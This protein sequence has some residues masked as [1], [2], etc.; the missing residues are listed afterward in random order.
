MGTDSAMRSQLTDLFGRVSIFALALGL[1][2]SATPAMAQNAEPEASDAA[3]SPDIIVTGS[4]IARSGKDAPTPVT[5]VGEADIARLALNTTSDI[6]GQIPQNSQFTSEANVGSGNFN[7]GASIANLRGLN[8]YYG[9]RTLTLVDSRRHV[10][11]TNGGAV[12]LNAIPA[13]LIKRVETVTG[14]ASAAYG[15]EAI[16]GV[17]N[18]ILDTRFSGLKAQFDYGVTTHG[19]GDDIHGA[20]AGGTSFANGRGHIVLGFEYERQDAISGCGQVRDWC[21]NGD[22]L[23]VNQGYAT[24][25]LPHYVRGPGGRFYDSDNG[26]FPFLN[27]QFNQA[28]SALVPFN[29]GELADPFL[30]S[31]SQMQGG[32]DESQD[33]YRSLALRPFVERYSIM[34][35]A[36]YEL[37]DALTVFVEGSYYK[38]NAKNQNRN[39]GA[40]IF[41]SAIA[42]DNAFLSP[43]ISTML[44]SLP[45]ALRA[46]TNNGQVLPPKLNN[47]DVEVFQGSFGFKGDLSDSWSWD[48][49]YSY[50]RNKVQ[51]RVANSKV[52]PFLTYA[53]DAVDNPATAAFDPVCRA[54]LPGPNFDPAAAGC[55]PLNLFGTGN[56]D[57]AAIAYAYRTLHQD[58]LYQQHVVAASANGELH[59]GWGAGPIKAAIGGEYRH[60][61]IANSHD[62]ANQPW[63]FGY[64][65]NFGGDFSGKLDA[66]EGFVELSVPVLRDAPLIKSLTLDG[67]LRQSHYRNQDVLNGTSRT[68][69]FT[70]WKIGGIWDLNDWFRVRASRSRDVRAPGFYELYSQNIAVGGPWGSV[71]NP[72]ASGV[73]QAAT[74]VLGGADSSTGVEKADTWTVGAIL[75]G[76]GALRGFYASADWYQIK[77]D[78]PIATLSTG[79]AV[80]NACF[81][82]ETFCDLIAGTG[83]VGS[84]YSTITQVNVPYLNLGQYLTR[85][86]DF[87]VGYQTSLDDRSSL[88]VRAMAN[89]QYDMLIDYGTG[90]PV[91]N[92][93]GVSGP[94][95]AFGY[96]NT[97]PKWQANAFVTYS[98]DPFSLTVQARWVGPGKFGLINP[99]TS[100]PYVAPGDPGYSTTD[101]N[102]INDNHMPGAVYINLS[103]SVQIPISKDADRK[104]E[105][106]GSVTN[107]FDKDPPA[108]PGGNGYPTNPVYFD[109]LG[110]AVRIG[111]RFQY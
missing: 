49:Y 5:I 11:T 73:T 33:T 15:S 93:A 55:V 9:T 34:G 98:R 39:N 2:I 14:G 17:V 47:T 68:S 95:A 107:L 102:S 81:Q 25:G 57:P 65:E 91:L 80:V 12:D 20:L 94:T 66:I 19:D 29:P 74:T 21:A 4:R 76:Q 8:P 101:I 84:G 99:D 30:Y 69:D 6:V 16:A 7:V 105:L 35:H 109:T 50:G 77:L 22:S 78:D 46:F 63:Y 103:G 28:G 23:F 70:T 10:P 104:L 3:S 110:R 52:V 18:V 83:P 31:R 36:E 54:T 62:L 97:S 60:E 88:D 56:A 72:W 41:Y 27:L 82:H 61:S 100:Q 92:N 53:L 38:R 48:A 44:A 111:V 106:F 89:Y 37:S 58:E 1:A 32:A 64:E 51:Q 24:N 75:T 85:G 96:F 45:P 87:E 59:Q 43:D 108:A 26:L 86:W 90:A 79:Q 42:P 71:I 40:S 13:L 67:A